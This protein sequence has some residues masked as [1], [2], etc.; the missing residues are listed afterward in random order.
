ML[1]KS[2]AKISTFI[3]TQ[4]TVIRMSHG[5]GKEAGCKKF[6]VTS[7]VETAGESVGRTKRFR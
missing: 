4:T 7:A 2:P 6:K 5:G 3:E 1:K